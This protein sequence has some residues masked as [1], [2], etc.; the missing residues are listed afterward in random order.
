MKKFYA[1][2][3]LVVFPFLA[4][5]Q[6]VVDE[7]ILKNQWL[8]DDK[9]ISFGDGTEKVQNYIN[10]RDDGTLG[11]NTSASGKVAISAGGTAEY[12][13]SATAADFGSNDIST[14]G[15]LSVGAQ[16]VSSLTSSGTLTGTTGAFT[17]VT[18]S[19]TGAVS[20][21]SNELRLASDGTLNLNTIAGGKIGLSVGGTNEY[22]FSN[23]EANFGTNNLI[24]TGGTSLMNVNLN[25]VQF[26]G[27][28]PVNDNQIKVGSDGS[29]QINS[30]NSNAVVLSSGGTSKMNINSSGLDKLSLQASNLSAGC[31]MSEVRIDTNATMEFC[32]CSA[33]SQWLCFSADTTNG[34][35]D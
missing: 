9:K 35:T 13:F 2:L 32:L 27:P 33:A 23:S 34:P 16:N 22:T 1:F 20:A 4:N 11:V 28:G 29:L 24:V 21:S 12:L 18:V 10:M 17:R 26:S 15:T 31:T 6:N 25:G 3:F 19:G 7:R 14:T 30:G 5:A 8:V